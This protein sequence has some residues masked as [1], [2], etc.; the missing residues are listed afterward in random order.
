MN[1]LLTVA[2]S[3]NIITCNLVGSWKHLSEC[4]EPSQAHMFDI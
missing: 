3:S 2:G 1:S 4:R